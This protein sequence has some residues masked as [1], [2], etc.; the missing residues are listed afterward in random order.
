MIT[1]NGVNP[2]SPVINIKEGKCVV[3]VDNVVNVVN[4]G[5]AFSI[6]RVR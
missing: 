1:S 4:D 5:L 3:S 2:G 6:Y